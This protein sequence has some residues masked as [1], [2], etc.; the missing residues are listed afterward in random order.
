MKF[1][2]LEY[3]RYGGF[4]RG[5]RK[6]GSIIVDAVIAPTKKKPMRVN[7]GCCVETKG[8]GREEAVNQ[9]VVSVIR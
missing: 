3:V 4:E 1:S 9:G 5:E 7:T 2:S 6:M 8:G